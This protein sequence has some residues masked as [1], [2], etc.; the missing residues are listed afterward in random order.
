[1]SASGEGVEPGVSPLSWE[2]EY[3]LAS[4]LSPTSFTKHT[5]SISITSFQREAW[6][7]S[8]KSIIID[9]TQDNI[10]DIIFFVL[11]TC[12]NSTK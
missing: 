4:R 9:L 7:N 5:S 3:H 6:Q 12:G 10:S 1:M 2:A 8:Y 11:S